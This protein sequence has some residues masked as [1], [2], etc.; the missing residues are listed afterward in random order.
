M[1][2]D[3]NGR[4]INT[5]SYIHSGE[6]N[7]NE[8]HRAMDYN[9]LGQPVIRTQGSSST[10]ISGNGN[11]DAFGRQQIA[12]PLTLFDSQHR[13]AQNDKFWTSTASGGTIVH[14][15]NASVV[16]M[17]VDTTSGSTAIMETSRVFPYQ[18]GKALEMFATFCMGEA[19]T[20]TCQ[21]IGYFGNDNGIYVEKDGDTMY[22]VRRSRVTGTVVN[23]RIPQTDWNTATLDGND[24]TGVTMDFTKSQ[25]LFIDIEWL[26]VGSVRVGFI[27]D[28]AFIVAHKFHHA[29]LIDSTYMTTAALPIRYEISNQDVVANSTTLKH[30]CST[31]IS[32]G[33]YSLTG[34]SYLSG[35]GLN[36]FV[37]SS[38]GTYYHLVSI[39]LDSTRL[40]DI[41]I[42]TA[43]NVLTDSNQN[44]EFKLVLNASFVTPLVFANHSN[45]A[46]E[47]SITNSAVSGNGTEL[48]TNYVINKATGDL[49]SEVLR[50]LQLSRTGNGPDI[51]SLIATG[52]SPNVK[53]TGNI[54]WIEPLRG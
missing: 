53:A 52:D 8:L 46:V 42:P 35:R 48:A 4:D 45:G 38:V 24:S 29:N 20:N 21:R 27:I 3:V 17:T 43:I 41:V 13:Y 51:L 40:D 26:G 34:K 49:S 5:T 23:T 47:Y 33:G 1:A 22:I 28:G 44:I 32:S 6:P 54:T 15:P 25:I 30:I 2:K 18:P 11:V 10:S 16:E 19:Q 31:V 37:M 39:R 14:D 12:S 7:L 50:E 36:Y 9:P